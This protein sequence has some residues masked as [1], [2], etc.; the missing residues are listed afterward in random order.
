MP[1][2]WEQMEYIRDFCDTRQMWRITLRFSSQAVYILFLRK[3]TEARN[4]QAVKFQ[5]MTLTDKPRDDEGKFTIILTLPQNE[6]PKIISELAEQVIR[7]TEAAMEESSRVGQ[8][9]EKRV[10]EW[11]AKK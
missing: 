10:Q 5:K 8:N 4:S 6:D 11:T 2:I 7:E 1:S 9:F 3:I